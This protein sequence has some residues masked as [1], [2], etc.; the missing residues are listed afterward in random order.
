MVY[1]LRFFLFKISLFHNFIVFGSCIIRILYTG[2]AKTKK[3]NNSG[4]KRLTNVSPAVTVSAKYIAV[5][6][7]SLNKDL[8]PSFRARDDTG[9][10][11]PNVH[12]S[13]NCLTN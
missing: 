6:V 11:L 1:T 12:S 10:W 9:R 3:N 13:S 5:A 2:C 4:S 7:Y 8:G